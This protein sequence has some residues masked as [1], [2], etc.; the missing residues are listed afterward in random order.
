MR[1]HRERRKRRLRSLTIDVRETEIDE[2][3]RRGRLLPNERTSGPAI[4]WAL[5]GFLDQYLKPDVPMGR[6][7]QLPTR[8]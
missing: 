2:L 8:R 5:C 6:W 4:A 1:R 3:I 7:P